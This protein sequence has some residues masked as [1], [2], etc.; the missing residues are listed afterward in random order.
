MKSIDIQYGQGSMTLQLEEGGP[1]EVASPRD[2]PADKGAVAKSL[3]QPLNFEDLKSFLAARRK[4]LVVINDLSRAPAA[5]ALKELPLCGKDF[6]SIIATGTHRPP[7]PQEMM[8]LLGGEAPRYG[9]KIVVHDSNAASSLKP[10][11]RTSRG[12]ELSFNSNVF[13]ADGIIAIG[14]VEPHYFAGF[15]GGRKFLLPALAGFRSIEMNHSFA[16]DERAK[17]LALEGNPVHEDFM[18]ALEIFARSEDIFSIQQVLNRE[19]QAAFASSGHII[20]SFMNAVER[21]KQTY[22]P[23]VRGK[24]DIVVA[25]AKPPL[26]LDLYQSQKAIENA[27]L[28]LSDGGILILVSKCPDGIGNQAFYKLLASPEEMKR[29]MTKGYEFGLHKALRIEELL[30]KA[31]IFAVT[32]LPSKILERVSISPFRDA[33]SAFDEATRL[34]GKESSVLIVDDA[35]VTVPVPERT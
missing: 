25:V 13:E 9:G 7:N 34:M 30:G 14:S 26:D 3:G 21:A 12:T 1:V 35:G 24:A 33:Q 28:A 32:D 20:N 29:V 22:A 2:V 8:R 31:R 6:V 17:L 15:T 4:I 27:K 11:G 23:S 16:L 10:L 19:H 5:S 18:E